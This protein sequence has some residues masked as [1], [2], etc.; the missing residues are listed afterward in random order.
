[1][2]LLH[3]KAMVFTQLTNETKTNTNDT[4]TQG[5]MIYVVNKSLHFSQQIYPSL[6][7]CQHRWAHRSL[8]SPL[9][10]SLILTLYKLFT[11]HPKRRVKIVLKKQFGKC[12]EEERQRQIT[13]IYKGCPLAPIALTENVIKHICDQVKYLFSV[14]DVVKV[15]GCRY[16]SQQV[17]LIVKAIFGDIPDAMDVE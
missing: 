15:I 17:F 3:L 4:L 10:P 11:G 1:M 14:E 7:T 6:H 16:T 8:P 9:P 2:F 12:L 13:Q 5:D